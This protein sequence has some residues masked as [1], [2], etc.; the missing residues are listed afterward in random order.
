MPY[1][2]APLKKDGGDEEGCFTR[3]SYVE[4]DRDPV[5]YA[6]DAERPQGPG[7]PALKLTDN[8]TYDREPDWSPNGKKIVYMRNSPRTGGNNWDIFVMNANGSG[9]K[10]LTRT[11]TVSEA[12]PAFSPDGI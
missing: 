3:K 12:Y 7:C 2:P 4:G 1:S 9:K 6:I 10:N 8:A 11:S 5:I